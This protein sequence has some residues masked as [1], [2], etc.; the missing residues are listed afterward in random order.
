M[1]NGK[2]PRR[3]I[4]LFVLSSSFVL[5][6][7]CH[8]PESSRE[9]ATST[10]LVIAS[11]GGAWQD[12]QKAAMF[13]PFAAHSGI[14]VRDV[15]YDGQYA[16]L[17]ETVRADR[18]EWDV[19]DVEGNMVVLGGKEALLQPI[20]YSV[21][22]RSRLLPEATHKFGVGIVAWAWVLA[23]RKG[24]LSE[25]DMQ[26][27]WR[28]FYDPD[29]VPGA[30]G[31]RNDPRRVLE[32]ALL[33]DGVPPVKLYPLDVDR[34][35]RRLDVFR[36]A[37]KRHKY[38]IVWWDEYAK[39]AQLL[40]DGEVVLTPAAN[41]RIADA[42][43]TGA[44]LEFSWNQGIVDFDWWVVPRNARR[45]ADAM[46][47]INFAA[48]ASSQVAIVRRIP[49]GPVTNDAFSALNDQEKRQLPTWPG[50]MQRELVFNTDWWASNLER[51]LPRWEAWRSAQ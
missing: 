1:A 9:P 17:R 26:A 47:F 41:G 27:P 44:P 8:K 48:Q 16:K 18:A 12:A 31:L 51:I 10:P 22:D 32:C 40:G 14:S 2:S 30:R 37:M 23:A 42:I 19:V 36:A 20:D 13:T 29:S 33:A 28:A 46:K 25:N 3:L 4:A 15:V 35:F 43:K 34:A 5:P 24:V 39:P 38:P 7:A 6:F 49:Y 11:Y 21:V 45:K 50:N